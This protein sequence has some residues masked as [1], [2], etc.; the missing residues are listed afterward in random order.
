[1]PSGVEPFVA[2]N[3][4]DAKVEECQPSNDADIPTPP[5]FSPAV[6]PSGPPPGSR[7]P[8]EAADSFRSEP[9]DAVP[10]PQ[11]VPQP[12]EL[13]MGRSQSEL[14]AGTGS[15][16]SVPQKTVGNRS[17]L[18]STQITAEG[19]A[20]PSAVK[21]DDDPIAPQRP[22]SS[23]VADRIEAVMRDGHSRFFDGSK[24]GEKWLFAVFLCPML[25]VIP[26]WIPGLP[27]ADET[28]TSYMV[29]H[30]ITLFVM[31]HAGSTMYPFVPGALL[32]V[33]LFRS[34]LVQF[35]MVPYLS[36]GIV[37]FGGVIPYLIFNVFPVPMLAV[38]QAA[39]I[40]PLVIVYFYYFM[41]PDVLN[42]KSHRADF[43]VSV[44]ILIG[45]TVVYGVIYPLGGALF[46]QLEGVPQAFMALAFCVVRGIYEKI[47]TRVLASRAQDGFPLFIFSSCFCHETF[48]AILMNRVSAWYVFAVFILYDL[49]ENLY[50]VW[51]L[52]KFQSM[53]P[54]CAKTARHL[55]TVA[56]L[57]EFA[58]MIAPF[59]YTVCSI[60]IYFFNKRPNDNFALVKDD[61]FWKGIFFNCLDVV[62]EVCV[63]IYL[64]RVIKKVT[65]LRAIKALGRLCVIYGVAFLAFQITI[66]GFFL[67]IQYAPGGN[68]LTF[69]FN[70]LKEGAQWVGGLCWTTPEDPLAC[71][72]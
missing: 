10:L 65:G 53:P 33:P 51:E 29:W 71:E 8:F 16:L 64:T 6:S 35:L 59:H 31:D 47:G 12:I 5:S 43:F 32:T 21:F 38:I 49:S 39:A 27:D 63:F 14:S 1:M 30:F 4:E 26:F 28:S 22:R 36:A 18:A 62:G 24:S 15:L 61:D 48:I 23:S 34:K 70:W 56:L 2:P 3:D 46:N 20:T 41:N 37:V 54:E 9:V 69:Q 57:M 17:S 44:G 60:A 58:E 45:V 52:R 7:R 55:V 40:I 11:G 19:H 25:A 50:H 42:S 67:Q 72:S 66:L 68:D 13:S